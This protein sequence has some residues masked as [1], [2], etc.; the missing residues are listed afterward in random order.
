MDFGSGM[1]TT[2]V[3]TNDTGARIDERQ[4]ADCAACA[5][6]RADHDPISL[7]FCEATVAGSYQRGCVCAAL[8]PRAGGI[9]PSRR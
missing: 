2:D 6:L 7:R 4:V 9:A 3:H 8:A 5:H 1:P